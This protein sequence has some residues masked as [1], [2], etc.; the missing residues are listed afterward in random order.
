VSYR[1]IIHVDAKTKRV[2]LCEG[3]VYTDDQ[4]VLSRAA[5]YPNNDFDKALRDLNE[6]NSNEDQSYGTYKLVETFWMSL[7]DMNMDVL[8]S[9]EDWQKSALVV[10]LVHPN[11]D[12]KIAIVAEHVSDS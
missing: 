4:D 11:D 1:F 2:N 9:L 7:A 8:S 3:S 6:W 10:K 5:E 12:K